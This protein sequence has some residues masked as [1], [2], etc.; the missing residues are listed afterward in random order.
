MKL[1]LKEEIGNVFSW[2]N[3]ILVTLVLFYVLTSC[4]TN[5]SFKLSINH[6][7]TRYSFFVIQFMNILYVILGIAMLL[8]LYCFSKKR[9]TRPSKPWTAIAMVQGVFFAIAILDS[10]GTLLQGIGNQYTPGQ[11]QTLLNQ[12]TIPIT[13][14][15]SYY[16]LKA[17]F[18]WWT[19]LG[20]T[21][22]ICGVLVTVIPSSSSGT[23]SRWYS[24]LIYASATLFFSFSFIWKERLFKT[25]SIKL[26]TETI[27]P[28]DLTT[29]VAFY[30]VFVTFVLYPIQ[31]VP[32]FGGLPLD[33]MLPNLRDG[34]NCF[35]GRNSQPGDMCP[36]SWLPLLLF[37]IFT[38]VSGV[39]AVVITAKGSAV[40]Q[41]LA[42]A[43]ILPLTNL[44]FSFK[45]IMNSSVES[46][47]TWSIIGLLVV[48][49]GFT[50]YSISD[51][52]SSRSR[53]LKSG[54][55]VD[56]SDS[57]EESVIG[58]SQPSPYGSVQSSY[59]NVPTAAAQARSWT[60]SQDGA[61]T[62]TAIPSLVMKS[63]QPQS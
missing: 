39:L 18:S 53:D 4:I 20:A 33:N 41:F 31:A 6:F 37:S 45:F 28:Y 59:Q 1:K 22:I 52:M 46:F 38:F 15:L 10:I 12:L 25:K 51:Y 30:M 42:N 5:I 60:N 63:I 23:S 29:Y 44:G 47:S 57:D 11:Y 21:V 24:M 17:R 27:S 8:V 7:Q 3:A 62:T 50:V 34:A 16:L 14:V 40:L 32:G 2:K 58:I 61:P 54:E 26:Q 56:F 43:A 19:I 49:G 55:V 9:R 36:D 13:M 35:L 48:L